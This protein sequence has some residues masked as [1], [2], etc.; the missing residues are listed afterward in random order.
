MAQL[1]IGCIVCPMS[2]LRRILLTI[3]AAKSW[4]YRAQSSTNAEGAPMQV[5]NTVVAAEL[6]YLS[7]LRSCAASATCKHHTGSGATPS[8]WISDE[9]VLMHVLEPVIMTVICTMKVLKSMLLLMIRC[10]LWLA[11]WLCYA[12]HRCLTIWC[13]DF[14]YLRKLVRQSTVS[15]LEMG[16][17]IAMVD[18]SEAK[19][20]SQIVSN[21]L[22]G[23]QSVL[24]S[25]RLARAMGHF[26]PHHYM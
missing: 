26:I 4:C 23:H 3:M 18:A 24:I 5:R 14:H 16:A 22:C 10:T 17:C 13:N 2:L 11:Q 12:L 8:L 19:K 7:H 1:A 21:C 25:V 15:P 20:W 9:E 6:F